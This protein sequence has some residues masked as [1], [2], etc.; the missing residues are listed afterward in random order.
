MVVPIF[1][2]KLKC[3]FIVRRAIHIHTSL[4][5]LTLGSNLSIP[6]SHPSVYEYPFD[7]AS[8]KSSLCSWKP[9][10]SIY[11][12]L[13]CMIQQKSKYARK[14]HQ[15]RKYTHSEQ[16]ERKIDSRS[17]SVAWFA[18][19]SSL[20]RSRIQSIIHTYIRSNKVI[21]HQ[22]FHFISE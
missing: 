10:A 18:M 11:L 17:S 2:Q 4:Q 8:I 5:R 20:C 3:S 12:C 14:C 6:F 1:T 7:S 15:R 19:F 9:I 22:P 16:L 13:D 21:T